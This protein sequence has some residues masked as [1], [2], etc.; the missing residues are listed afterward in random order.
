MQYKDYYKTLGVDRNATQEVIKKTYRKLASKFHPDVSKEKNAEERFKQI[1]EAYEV[2]K[3]PE[4]RS[5]YD[6][7]GSQ[8]K[9]GQEFRPPPGWNNGFEFS[10][11][12]YSQGENTRFGEFFESLFGRGR[13]SP[14]QRQYN[15]KVQQKDHHTKIAIDLI[16]AYQGANRRITLH[17][18]VQNKNGLIQNNKRVLNVRI[19]K[20]IKQGQRIR[21]V[22]QG[23]PGI[24]GSQKGDLY[25][26]VEFKPHPVFSI[27][28]R[29]VHLDLPVTPWEAALGATVK[30]PTPDGA[31]ELKIPPSSKQGNRIRL[32]ERGI[33]GSPPGHFYVTLQIVLPTADTEKAKNI[34]QNMAQE[35]AFNPREKFGL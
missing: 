27:T 33:P 7:L 31:V 9:S 12:G 3:D 25:L 29:D 21:L 10:S 20:G 18:P 34:Y 13:K 22:G 28:D 35:L 6:Q 23:M 17:T 26:E 24:G 5:A 16:D 15:H 1:G 11:K 14:S 2:L 32:K 4:K 30:I 8:W 19:P